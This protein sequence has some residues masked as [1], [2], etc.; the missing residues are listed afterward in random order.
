MVEATVDTLLEVEKVEFYINNQL[1][2]TS[3]GN[4]QVHS[5]RWAEP[6]LFY[7]EIKIVAYDIRGNTDT[8]EIGVTM[9]NFGIIP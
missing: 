2:N 4:K 3:W 9:F 6:V 1:V 7:H 5:W 8:D